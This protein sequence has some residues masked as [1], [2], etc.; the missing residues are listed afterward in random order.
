MQKN[1]MLGTS[2]NMLLL[3]LSTNKI[4][5]VNFNSD[6]ISSHEKTETDETSL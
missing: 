1:K 6:S 3:C 2:N 5:A 4:T